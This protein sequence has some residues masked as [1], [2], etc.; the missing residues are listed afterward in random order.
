MTGIS[1]DTGASASDGVTDDNTL[2]ISG[3]AEAGSSVEVRLDGVAIGTVQA[4]GAGAW[5]LDH[6]GTVLAEGSYALSAVATDGAGNVSAPSAA[7][8]LTIVA[9]DTAAPVLQAFSSTTADGVYGPGAAIT[10]VASFDEALAA[11]SSLTVVLDNG[12]SVVL[13]TV[14]GATVSGVYTVGA[15]GSGADSADLTVASIAAMAVSD[16]AGNLQ[17]ATA[18]PA[19]NLG[20]TSALV[21]DTTAPPAPAVTGISEDTGAS[22]SDGGDVRFAAFGD[23]GDGNGTAAVANLVKSM[24][25]DFII[26]TGDN[27]YDPNESIDSQIGRHYSDY[28]GNYSGDFGSGSPVNRFFPTLGNHDYEEGFIDDYLDY[29][30]L[31]G[32]ERYYEFVAGPVH[33]FAL[34]SDAEPD[35]TSGTSI[36]AQW[37][38]GRLAN[39]NSPYNIVYFHHPPYNSGSTHGPS[40][41]MR[42]PFE[43]WGATAV[44]TGHEHVYERILRDDN[45]DGELLPYFISGL[46]GNG[47]YAGFDTPEVGSQ[48]RY[49]SDYGA[50]VVQANNS[51]ITFEF[52][53]IGGNLIDS[54]VI[55]AGSDIGNGFDGV[56]SDTTLVFQGTAEAGDSVEVRLDGTAIGTVQ[57]DAAG[58]WSLDY[59][60]FSLAEGS[61]TLT[62]V[63]TDAAGNVSAPSA[64]FALTIDTTPPAAPSAPDLMAASDTGASSTDD[65]T[66][67]S[68]P[69]F[70]GSAEP[71]STVR[72]YADGAPIGTT[73]ADGTGAWTFVWAINASAAPLVDG[74]YSITATATDVAGNTS[75]ASQGLALTIDTSAEPTIFEKRVISGLDDVEESSSGYLYINSSDLELTTDGSTVQTVG[76]RFTDV[77]I[78]W[79]AV[80]TSAYIQFVTDEVKTGATSLL[81]RG[82]DSDSAAAISGAYHN[83]S[84]RPMTTASTAWAPAGWTTVGAAGSA[85]A[86]PDLS[87]I[88]Q[89]II[90]RNGWAAHNNMMF[91]VTGTGTRTAVAYEGGASNA[92]LLHIEYTVPSNEALAPVVDLDSAAPGS[93]H[94]TTFHEN[95][96][97]VPISGFVSITDADSSTLEFATISLPNALPG[98]TLS[99]DLAGLPAGITVDPG[100]TASSVLLIGTASLADYETA[101]QSVKYSS[102]S[103]AP[104]SSDRLINV[105]VS[106]GVVRSDPVVATI[107][108]DQAPDAIN[109]NVTTQHD[110]AVVTGNVLANDDQGDGPAT[111]TGF[112]STSANGATV[113]SNGDGTFTYTPVPGFVGLDSFNYSI[114][115]TDGDASGAIVTVKVTNPSANANPEVV[116]IHNMWALG[117]PD[118][119]GIAWNPATGKLILSDSEIDEE[120]TYDLT[121]IFEFN[122]NGTRTASFTPPY[123]TE[124][125]GLAIDALINRMY[126]SDDDDAIVYVVDPADPETLYWSFTTDTIGGLGGDDPEGVAIDPITHHLFVVNGESRTLQEIAV[127]QTTHTATLVDSFVFSDPQIS[128]PEAIAYDPVHDV[129]LVGGG[130]SA[131]IWVVD[132]SG[133]TLQKITL[134]ESYR[135]DHT[136]NG[137]TIRTSVKDL[138]LAPASDGSG[139]TH[140]YVAD[141]GNSHVMDGRIVEVDLGS[142]FGQLFV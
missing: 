104:G 80:I 140:L 39:S 49:N 95:G 110:T 97:A 33:F 124:P 99:V 35:G 116:V 16:G 76:I 43:S 41:R 65:V 11:G 75:S 5:S 23:W 42:W 113:V 40:E 85:Q 17:G 3:T 92:P 130:F 62:A 136:P 115:D 19:S 47:I 122:L 117:I 25:V 134:L 7:F 86:S 29:F 118:P 69:D 68:T 71:G 63:V 46:G 9:A 38:Q 2:V 121:D 28:I 55:D 27:L 103:D 30:T 59:T 128:D 94:A 48:V 137:G 57:A 91:V 125:T 96:A 36:Q 21:V 126:V 89:E 87:P 74:S 112:Q 37:L 54:Y 83:V 45:G 72:L 142:A 120:P 81:I 13:S 24:N 84:S 106:D 135:N 119:A 64:D 22:A 127:N 60:A 131:D 8:A 73:T 129:F 44:L 105:R 53:S 139:E 15:T 100:S 90:D 78:P 67:D 77:D 98:D 102:S 138:E 133:D 1:E 56:T 31:P 12:A 66:G 70:A 10:L 14:A 111:I 26:T 108:I 20:D 114:A 141:F 107:A 32:N 61:Y 4:D 109:D 51:E 52:W 123:T 101:L 50:M 58:I 18:L 82:V 132:R 79:G 93:G 88:V 34:N 6:S